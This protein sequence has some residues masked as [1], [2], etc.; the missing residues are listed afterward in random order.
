MAQN[1]ESPIAHLTPEAQ[2]ITHQGCTQRRG[3][4]LQK[5]QEPSV[6]GGAVGGE[7]PADRHRRRSL[8]IPP[9]FLVR[10]SELA[11]SSCFQ[12]PTLEH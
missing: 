6:H 2:S 3:K 12:L 8:G 4:D 10:K 5:P 11:F 9:L 7:G 1:N